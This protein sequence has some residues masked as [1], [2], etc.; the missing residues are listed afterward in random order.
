MGVLPLIAAIIITQAL[1]PPVCPDLSPVLRGAAQVNGS[2]LAEHF[3]WM[4]HFHTKFLSPVF[5]T[6][7]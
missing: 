1:V 7:L 4:G 5:S 6:V 2:V 3:P